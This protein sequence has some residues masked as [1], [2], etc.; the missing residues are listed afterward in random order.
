M[1][2][3][4]GLGKECANI[5]KHPAEDTTARVE[6]AIDLLAAKY[7]LPKSVVNARCD[8]LVKGGERGKEYL[9]ADATSVFAGGGKERKISRAKANTW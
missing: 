6:K 5:F 4:Q 3:S 7:T 8:A 9:G 2:W 1:V